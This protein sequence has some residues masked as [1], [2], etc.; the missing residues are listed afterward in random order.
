M[1]HEREH[2]AAIRI[3]FDPDISLMGFNNR[4]ADR[5]TKPDSL[6]GHF[7]SVFYLVKLEKDLLLVFVRNAR[8]RIPNGNQ[9]RALPAL[10]YPANDLAVAW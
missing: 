8:T 2:A 4:L 3:V 1:Q 9:D 10:A 5:K 7:P 6:P